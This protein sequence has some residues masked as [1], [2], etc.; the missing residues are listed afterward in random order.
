MREHFVVEHKPF[1][2]VWVNNFDELFQV[3]LDV[4]GLENFAWN[5]IWLLDNIF[6]WDEVMLLLFHSLYSCLVV[7][8]QEEVNGKDW[9]DANLWFYRNFAS[10][11]L[12]NA[13]ADAES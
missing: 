5:F 3:L 9:P 13:L 1:L 11:L 6:V 12:A 7:F 2:N 8:L 4:L 10:E